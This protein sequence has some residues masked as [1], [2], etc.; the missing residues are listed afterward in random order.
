MALNVQRSLAQGLR[1]TMPRVWHRHA[2]TFAFVQCFHTQTP[3]C[4]DNTIEK[5]IATYDIKFRQS[6]QKNKE[7]FLKVVEYYKDYSSKYQ[8]HIDFIRSAMKYMDEYGVNRD[9]ETYKKIIDV[10][11]KG[12]YIARNKFQ[13]IA[14][15]Y[16]VH[17]QLI[18]DVL[19]K[20]ERNRLMPDR[21]MESILLNIFG[22]HGLPTHKYWRMMYWMPKFKHLD[23]WP[24]D[25]EMEKDPKALST[26]SLKKMTTNDPQTKVTEFQTKDLPDTIED[27][28][29][30]SSMSSMQEDLLSV[31][32]PTDTLFIEGP[33]KVWCGTKSLDYFV[34]RG[35]KIEREIIEADVISIDQVEIPYHDMR[36][37]GIPLSVYEQE[38]GTY[39]AMCVTGTSSKE[40]LVSWIRFLEKKNP[41]LAKVPVVFKIKSHTERGEIIEHSLNMPSNQK[42]LTDKQAKTD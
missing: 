29:I 5:N 20:M 33:G 2:K 34:L 19:D 13:V 26:L 31:L 23:P 30:M 27:T 39:Y 11:P 18:V 32:K 10:L 21:E 25:E 41:N 37:K 3:L 12:K 40:S 38:D 24:V 4:T 9:L 35:K 1:V 7:T 22:R 28:W 42:Q 15:Y 17:Q 6:P 16:P 36:K 14:N 8:T